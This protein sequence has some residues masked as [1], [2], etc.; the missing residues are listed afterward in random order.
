MNIELFVHNIA[1]K[2]QE[3]SVSPISLISEGWRNVGDAEST[4]YCCALG[5]GGKEGGMVSGLRAH[6]SLSHRKRI[7]SARRRWRDRRGFIHATIARLLSEEHYKFSRRRLAREARRHPPSLLILKRR[8]L[9]VR[10]PRRSLATSR[11]GAGLDVQK[12]QGFLSRKR[13]LVHLEISFLTPLLVKAENASAAAACLQASVV[14]YS[15]H[16]RTQTNT[17]CCKYRLAARIRTATPTAWP[18]WP[19]SLFTSMDL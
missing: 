10:P 3:L 4:W 7:L 19:P 11:F 18:M 1:C 2:E 15:G 6:F 5:E 16:P 9:T 8:H 12:A 17:E 13:G 14:I